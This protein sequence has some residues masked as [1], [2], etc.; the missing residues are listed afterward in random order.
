MDNCLF[1]SIAAGEKGTLRYQDDAVVAFDDI[2]PKAP[3]H[4]LI[5]PKK[6]I[7]SV[8]TLADGDEQ[9]VG[10]MVRIAKQ[11]A[12]ERK[13]ADDGYRLVLNTRKHGGQVVDH[14]HLHLLGGQPLGH[15][16]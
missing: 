15:M 10:H 12:E 11:L 2:A 6:H 5:V 3:V 8:A 14:I 4:I 9:L 16:V 13:I 7:E 1:C